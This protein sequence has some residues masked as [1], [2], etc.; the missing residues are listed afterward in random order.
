MSIDSDIHRELSG[1]QDDVIDLLDSVD[2][3][4]IEGEYNPTE[5]YASIPKRDMDR[6]KA[7]S[8]EKN[9]RVWGIV[10]ALIVGQAIQAGISQ[11]KQAYPRKV[12]KPSAQDYMN[13]YIKEHGGEFIKGMSR[14]DQQKLVGFIWYNADK[15]ERPLAKDLKNLPWTRSLLDSGNHRAATIIRTEKHR[16]TSYGTHN[17]A[18]DS[19]AKF[20]VRHEAGDKRTRPSHRAIMGERKPIDEPYSNSEMYPGEKDINCRGWES[21]EW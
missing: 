8:Q 2:F 13:R 9:S 15:N 12:G 6:Y 7:A 16:A 5:L 17:A 21:F 14:T 3:F 10:K 20:H 1:F 18:K 4:D 19:K 11:L